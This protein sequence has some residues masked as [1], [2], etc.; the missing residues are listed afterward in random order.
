MK[1][2]YLIVG[3]GLSGAIF[4][5]EA[6]KKG[7]KCLVIEKRSHIGGNLYCENIEGI[8]VHK[9]GAHI[10][11]TNDKEIWDYINQFV[12]FNH[13]INSPIAKYKNK[14][15]NLPFNMNTFHQMWGCI[16]PYEHFLPNIWC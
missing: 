3:A 12:S 9:Y 8:Q 1:Y 7:Y 5:Y 11:R 14:I 2:D 4:A 16:T 15:Y 13:Y 10:F 6:T